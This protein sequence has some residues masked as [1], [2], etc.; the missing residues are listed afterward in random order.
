MRLRKKKETAHVTELVHGGAGFEPRNVDGLA[1][2]LTPSQRPQLLS[3]PRL[4][5]HGPWL[6]EGPSMGTC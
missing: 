2:P 5:S 3:P 6:C 1:W 4:R